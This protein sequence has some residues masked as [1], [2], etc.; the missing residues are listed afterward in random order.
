MWRKQKSV[1]YSS[2]KSV[3]LDM[4][5]IIIFIKNIFTTPM[6]LDTLFACLHFS[7]IML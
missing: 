6:N 2:Q 3:L 7:G 4:S 1:V 5:F